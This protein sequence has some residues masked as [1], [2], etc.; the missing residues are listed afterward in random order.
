MVRSL[1]L[2]GLLTL[3]AACGVPGTGPASGPLPVSSETAANTFVQV[4]ARVEPV[5]EDLCRSQ[6]RGINCDFLILVD[7]SRDAGVNAFQSVTRDGRPAIVFTAGMI[8]E[9]RN[10]D[11]LAFV[12]GHEAAHH[13]AGHLQAQAENAAAGAVIFAG[14]ATMTGGTAADIASAQE[15]GAFVGARAYSKE[16]ELEADQIGTIITYRAGYDPL[17]GAAFFTRIPDPG[18][19]FLGTHPPNAARMEAVRSTLAR[20]R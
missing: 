9:A 4:V 19:Q 11:E 1:A 17:K 8:T 18:D 6:T 5:A 14:L 2:I 16:F 7:K 10:A 3:L 20:I 15:L 13:L 12:L